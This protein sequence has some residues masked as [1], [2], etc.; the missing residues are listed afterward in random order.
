LI[1]RTTDLGTVGVTTLIGRQ[2]DRQ[3]DRS[4]ALCL[5][6]YRR[7]GDNKRTM[8]WFIRSAQIYVCIELYMHN[9]MY[10]LL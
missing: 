5:P 2:T 4:I 8:D 1:D 6:R 7:A 9:L 3:T 10:E